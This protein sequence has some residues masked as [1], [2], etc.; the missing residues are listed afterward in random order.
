MKAQFKTWL[1]AALI[2]LNPW[3][4]LGAKPLAALVNTE[5]F[6]CGHLGIVIVRS[7]NKPNLASGHVTYAAR[8]EIPSR[9]KSFTGVLHNMMAGNDR[10][11]TK[12]ASDVF[13]TIDETTPRN[14]AMMNIRVG[15]YFY[16]KKREEITIALLQEAYTCI[17]NR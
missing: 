6:N 9:K 1:G 17:P 15:N 14:P 4:A 16:S 7:S 12:R 11:F 8:L 5:T 3:Q 2:G 10:T 13:S